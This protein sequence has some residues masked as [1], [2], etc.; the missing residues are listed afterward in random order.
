MKMTT[1]RLTA[2]IGNRVDFSVLGLGM[3]TGVSGLL[4]SAGDDVYKS[5][6]VTLGTRGDPCILVGMIGKRGGTGMMGIL[7]GRRIAD[8]V[9]RCGCVTGAG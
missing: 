9:P 2:Q 7:V 5:G 1:N 6:E 8:D 4:A 3:T